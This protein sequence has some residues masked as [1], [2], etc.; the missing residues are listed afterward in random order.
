ME[1]KDIK[2]GDRVS[3]GGVGWGEHGTV[4][5]MDDSVITFESFQVDRAGIQWVYLNA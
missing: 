2:I 3:V 5:S 4:V 1:T